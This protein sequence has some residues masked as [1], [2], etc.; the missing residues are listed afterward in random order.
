MIERDSIEQREIHPNSGLSTDRAL[1][2]YKGR[3]R[4]VDNPEP[5]PSHLKIADM[6]PR[7]PDHLCCHGAGRPFMRD[8]RP[9]DIAL[10]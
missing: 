3:A 1:G 5:Q 8:L 9:D 6:C 4:S 2:L 7:K 10:Q